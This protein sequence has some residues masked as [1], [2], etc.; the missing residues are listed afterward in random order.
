M[1]NGILCDVCQL[2]IPIG[3]ASCDILVQRPGAKVTRTLVRLI[4]VCV[5]CVDGEPFRHKK[6]V[7]KVAKV[8]RFSKH[9]DPI[10]KV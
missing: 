1:F 10:T 5:V 8:R 3:T 6:L 9:T 2:R 4:D 7:L